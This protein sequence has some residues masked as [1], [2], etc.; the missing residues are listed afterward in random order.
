MGFIATIVIGLLAGWIA[1]MIMKG[2]GGGYG[3][4]GD[5]GLGVVGSIVGGWLG[6][7]LTGVDLTT[8][9]N[10]TTLV[11][12]VIGAVIVIAIYRLITRRSLTR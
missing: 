1:G 8:G 11:V 4:W 5:L 3:L 7:L 12:S 9:F 2:G 6:S 10:L